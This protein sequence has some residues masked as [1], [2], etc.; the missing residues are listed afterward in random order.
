MRTNFCTNP[1][2]GSNERA[3]EC[4]SDPDCSRRH[5]RRRGLSDESTTLWQQHDYLEGK[6]EK[7]QY[8]EE[9]FQICPQDMSGRTYRG[10]N[11]VPDTIR[12]RCPRP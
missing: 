2:F 1:K 8:F 10:A 5:A 6:A 12:Y 7:V 9:R 4:R 3:A 11:K